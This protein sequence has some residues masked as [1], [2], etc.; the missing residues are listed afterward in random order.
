MKRS[1]PLGL[2][3]YENV[4]AGGVGGDP[5]HAHFLLQQNRLKGLGGV[6][7]QVQ[8]HLDDP[9]LGLEAFLLKAHLMLFGLHIRDEQGLRGLEGI[10][11]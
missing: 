9:I 7:L 10:Q 11:A 2:A 6:L 8:G 4:R 3:V 1:G 5:D